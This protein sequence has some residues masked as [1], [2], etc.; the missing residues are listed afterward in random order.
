MAARRLLTRPA[1][2][3]SR[4][5]PTR[6]A[7]LCFRPQMVETPWNHEAGVKPSF[8]GTLALLCSWASPVTSIVRGFIHPA[9]EAAKCKQHT[10]LEDIYRQADARFVPGNIGD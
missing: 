4:A 2:D 8:T 9:E 1:V 10:E 7:H 3:G 6:P 5:A